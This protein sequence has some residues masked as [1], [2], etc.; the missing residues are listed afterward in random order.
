MWYYAIVTR[1]ADWL[2]KQYVIW[3]AGR[4]RRFGGDESPVAPSTLASAWAAVRSLFRWIAETLD[5][6]NISQTLR[7]PQFRP[8]EMTPLTEQEVK[9]LLAAVGRTT[10]SIGKRD[11]FTMPRT[12]AARDRA[13]LLVLLD[14]GLR[15]GECARLT[16]Q[17]V[18]MVTGEVFVA[19]YG[20]GQKTKSRRVYLG[21][22]AR[23]AVWV[24]MSER[25]YR[26]DDPLWV[27]GDRAMTANAMQR[28]IKRLGERAGIR[29]IHPHLFR[30]TFAVQFLRGGG[31]VFELQR[32]LGHSSL[33]MVKHYVRL[34]DADAARA[35]ASAAPADRWK[36]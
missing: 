12:T 15:I 27:S 16:A 34:A 6:P 32:L 20:S 21:K 9:S 30:H 11:A 2:D 13:L 14:T 36:L 8:A 28:I 17:D 3:Q 31:G 19:P 1:F 25:T 23:R 4:P 35:H 22:T 26:P 18:D 33:E 24:Y 29:H 7:K 5:R 10:P